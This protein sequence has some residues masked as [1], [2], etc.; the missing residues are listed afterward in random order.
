M[1][2][3]ERLA[4]RAP[5]YRPTLAAAHAIRRW[6]EE[7]PLSQDAYYF[8]D[9]H[10]VDGERYRRRCARITSCA[11]SVALIGMEGIPVNVV[12]RHAEFYLRLWPRL[13]RDS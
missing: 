12:R 7:H 3:Q 2:I 1:T 9:G 10:F 6:F 13:L 5:A 4:D 11:G 8:Y